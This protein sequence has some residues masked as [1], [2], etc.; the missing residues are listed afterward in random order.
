LHLHWLLPKALRS[1]WL[2]GDHWP[3]D[4]R[5]SVPV[6]AGAAMMCKREMIADIGGFDPLI[7]MYAEDLEWCVRARRAGWKIYFEPAAEIIHIRE[8]SCQQRWSYDERMMVQENAMI[9]FE[10][11][12][13]SRS[14]NLING[15]SRVIVML[16][17]LARWK[18]MRRKTALISALIQLRLANCKSLLFAPRDAIRAK[19]KHGI[20]TKSR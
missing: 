10:N 11:K 9:Y 17:H 5:R 20:I 15:I 13:F 14:L 8:K 16:T 4:V 7:H 18:I 19:A 1:R 6:I 12:S 2:L 3:H